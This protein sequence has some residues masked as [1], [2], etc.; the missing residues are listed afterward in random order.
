MNIRMEEKDAFCD[1]GQRDDKNRQQRYLVT[2]F[3]I[4]SLF[5]LGCGKKPVA[6]AVK[7]EDALPET[8]IEISPDKQTASS[9]GPAGA[10][11]PAPPANLP[12]PET[13]IAG[14]TPSSKP[15]SSGSA[16][17]L[18]MNGKEASSQPSMKEIQ[19][20]LTNCKLYEGKIDGK[21]GPR[22]KKAIEAF[23]KQNNLSPDGRVGPKTWEKLKAYLNPEVSSPAGTSAAETGTGTRI[24]K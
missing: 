12:L 15:I 22:T 19:K 5:V 18:S 11:P 13:S 7:P 6:K 16:V 10:I 2:C 23:Q 24:K 17:E 20:A 9:P 1:R 4:I 14:P 8:T 3:F 21:V